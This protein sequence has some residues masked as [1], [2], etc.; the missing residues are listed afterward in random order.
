MG[1]LMDLM[2]YT[3]E[4]HLKGTIQ[5]M[6][7]PVILPAKKFTFFFTNVISIDFVI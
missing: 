5:P 6:I 4:L 7:L 3:I 2:A 1:N